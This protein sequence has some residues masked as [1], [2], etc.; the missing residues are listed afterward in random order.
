MDEGEST[1]LAIGSTNS[2]GQA[3][4][5]RCGVLPRRHADHAH[6]GPDR[7]DFLIMLPAPNLDDRRFQDLVD[8]AKRL[9]QQRCPHLDRS[10]RVGPRA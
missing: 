7:R 3:V 6:R 9:V 8:D 1:L 2:S 5:Y 10:Q 4:L